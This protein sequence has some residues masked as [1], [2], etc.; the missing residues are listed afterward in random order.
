[1]SVTA[2]SKFAIPLP[3]P[4]EQRAIA[5]ALS[6][7]DALIGALDQLIAKK[8]DLKQAAMQQLLT[9]QTRLPGFHGEWE[10]KHD[11]DVLAEDWRDASVR[12]PIR[13]RMFTLANIHQGAVMSTQDVR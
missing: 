3:P 7:V 4:P 6:D 9:G 12:M 1:M 13:L 5:G 2:F 10:V 11:W 8:R